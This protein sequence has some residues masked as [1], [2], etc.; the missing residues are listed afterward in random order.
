MKKIFNL[1]V[2]LL[3]VAATATAQSYTVEPS[4]SV[5]KWSGKK[6]GKEHFGNIN[7]KEGKFEVKNN[8]VASGKFII[9]M[10]SIT[11]EDMQGEWADKLVG[12]LKSDD[13]FGTANYPEAIL[14][15]KESTKLVNGKAKVKADLTI[16]GTTH[17]VEFEATQTGNEFNASVTFDRSLY[18]V[19]YGSG[20]FFDDLG[21]KAIYDDI[22]I[23]VKLIATK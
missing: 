18:N 16:K 21:D 5:L 15:L 2:I 11:D 6:I 19:R 8:K 12:H 10:T 13:F 22:T 14:V 9:D 4:K 1:A 23:E 3:F 20:K 7:L 17:P